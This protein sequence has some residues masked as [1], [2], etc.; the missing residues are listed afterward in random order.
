MQ[1]SHDLRPKTNSPRSLSQRWYVFERSQIWPEVFS[2]FLFSLCFRSH[3]FIPLSLDFLFFSSAEDRDLALRNRAAPA[4]LLAP[5]PAAAPAA[6]P[7]APLLAPP[8]PPPIDAPP[9]AIFPPA[10]PLLP[11]PEA[12]AVPMEGVV[13]A[14]SPVLPPPVA[15]AVPME[16]VI[17]AE[18]KKRVIDLDS[19]LNDAIASFFSSRKA[20]SLAAP[21][22]AGAPDQLPVYSVPNHLTAEFRSNEPV[23]PGSPCSVS[24]LCIW[25]M[26]LVRTHHSTEMLGEDILHFFKYLLCPENNN[27][28]NCFKTIRQH[29]SQIG[30]QMVVHRFVFSSSSRVCF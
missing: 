14:A 26:E 27:V 28:P 12:D 3:E 4:H 9:P 17:E 1:V 11:P 30:T 20:P 6:L 13:H 10:S 21:V 8:P 5:R 7:L 29:A 2:I 24:F 23:F 22:V 16:G 19:V 18:E 15:A 25:L